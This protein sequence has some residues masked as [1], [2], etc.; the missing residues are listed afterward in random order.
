MYYAEWIILVTISLWVSLLAFVWAVRS[1]QFADQG[2]ARY[3]P[4]TDEHSF[5]PPQPPRK[6]TIEGFALLG[7]AVIG[8]VGIVSAI[9]LSLAWGK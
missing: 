6:Y 1:G 5:A 3:L 8:L 4:L 7:I 9:I 2:R